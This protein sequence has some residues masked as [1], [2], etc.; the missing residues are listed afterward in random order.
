M[1]ANV[2]WLLN[3]ADSARSYSEY[4]HGIPHF[5]PM[6][7]RFEANAEFMATLDD[8]CAVEQD[9]E[10]MAKKKDRPAPICP[11][12][13]EPA[14]LRRD[15]SA[16]YGGIDRGPIW[17][18]YPC[19]AWVGCHPD[20]T[21]PLGRL[22]DKKLRRAKILAHAHFDPLWVAKIKR[23]GCT[24]K[25]ARKAGYAWLAAQLG[26]TSEQCHIGLFDLE[27]CRRVVEICEALK[28]PEAA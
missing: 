9:L 21:A 4:H 3:G 22:A 23:D 13:S 2:Q 1:D 14:K 26:L 19:H 6:A 12:C 8:R 27:Q 5:E 25:E 10:E 18:C 24:K 28:K 16:F 15:S 17:E 11:Y 7:L 20:T